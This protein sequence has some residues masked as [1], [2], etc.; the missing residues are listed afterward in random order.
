[1][2]F[3]QP[4]EQKPI[5]SLGLLTGIRELLTRPGAWLQHTEA[6]TKTRTRVNAENPS[7][8]C[9]CIQ[10]AAIR[11]ANPSGRYDAGLRDQALRILNTEIRETLFPWTGQAW[12]FND[13]AG[14]TQEEVLQLLEKTI[15]RLEA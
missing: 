10:G 15:S 8:I 5:T 3:Q 1:M 2:E 12:E 11:T 7:A 9:F 14:R 4:A 6:E 13:A